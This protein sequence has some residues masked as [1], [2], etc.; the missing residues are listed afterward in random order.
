MVCMVRRSPMLTHYAVLASVDCFLL[1][2]R[3]GC[4][5][6]KGA[7]EGS[8]GGKQ[9]GIC[10]ASFKDNQ[11]LNLHLPAETPGHA[12]LKSLEF[13]EE[14]ESENAGDAAA[15]QTCQGVVFGDSGDIKTLAE[16]AYDV[17]EKAKAIALK[18]LEAE[19]AQNSTIFL[20]YVGN[21]RGETKDGRPHGLGVL[22]REDG[23]TIYE[24]QWADHNRTGMGVQRFESGD[25]AYA[26]QFQNG[27][28]DGLGVSSDADGSVNHAGLWHRREPSLSKG[29]TM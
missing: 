8:D 26:G 5:S 12:G 4:C 10:S 6:I 11:L 23:S 22:R 3:G 2:G 15:G 29:H 25:L 19:A 16:Q 20:R 18:A 28:F 9:C 27:F 24:G 17:A 1:G 13:V 14:A 7:T 21:Y